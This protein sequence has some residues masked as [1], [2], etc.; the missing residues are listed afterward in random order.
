MLVLPLGVTVPSPPEIVQFASA[1]E[2]VSL[3]CSPTPTVKRVRS[4]GAVATVCE[5]M[6]AFGVGVG[7]G[8]LPGCGA[9]VKGCTDCVPGLFTTLLKGTGAPLP[10]GPSPIMCMLLTCCGLSTRT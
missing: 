4:A 9:C 7:A 10:G 2:N 3:T 8:P 6:V 5:V 1:P